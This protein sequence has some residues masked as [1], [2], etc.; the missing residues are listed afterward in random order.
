MRFQGLGFVLDVR[1]FGVGGESPIWLGHSY[2][3]E[4]SQYV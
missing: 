4:L 1:A 3:T 2:S